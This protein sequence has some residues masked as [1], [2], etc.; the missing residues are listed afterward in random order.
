VRALRSAA[1]ILGGIAAVAYPIAVF[2]GLTHFGA[3]AVSAIVLA[4]LVVGVGWRFRGADRATVAALVRMAIAMLALLGAGALTDDPRFVLALPV[5]VNGT[6]L[7][8][9]GAT[10]RTGE[11]PMIERFARMKEPD[12]DK[13][14]QR[15]CRQWTIAWCAFFVL[16][17][18]IALAL[19]LAA[20]LSWWAVY[21]GGI[22]YGLMGVMFAAEWFHRRIRFGP[23]PR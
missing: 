12:L 17:G 23:R 11:V 21:T 19:A 16:N 8:E 2:V 9:F 14:Q 22:A 18:A 7:I 5:L 3:R 20:P 6:L 15:H 13:T 4:L 10:L 1:A